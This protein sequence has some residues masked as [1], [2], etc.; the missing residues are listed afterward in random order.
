MATEAVPSSQGE[1]E[2]W[3]AT[4]SAVSRAVQAAIKQNINP[5][6]NFLSHQS[7]CLAY[8]SNF[9]A[10]VNAIRFLTATSS[11]ARHLLLLHAP[12]TCR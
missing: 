6:N 1:W 10:I 9:I 12:V 7:T 11:S 4:S 5:S 8:S 2:G 3:G